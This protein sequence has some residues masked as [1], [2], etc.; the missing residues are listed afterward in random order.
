[1]QLNILHCRQDANPPSLLHPAR[2][3]IWPQGQC[4]A[5]RLRNCIVKKGRVHLAG[6]KAE[7]TMGLISTDPGTEAALSKWELLFLQLDFP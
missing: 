7:G 4:L 5:V 3:I 6:L 2:R 1:M